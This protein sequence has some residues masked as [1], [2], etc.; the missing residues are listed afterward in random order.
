MYRSSCIIVTKMVYTLQITFHEFLGFGYSLCQYVRTIVR[1]RTGFASPQ[2]TGPRNTRFAFTR[3]ETC[4][5][6]TQ[7]SNTLEI[8]GVKCCS[9]ITILLLESDTDLQSTVL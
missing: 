3:E 4:R 8:K 5:E 6:M 7:K 9:I 2:R 1:G